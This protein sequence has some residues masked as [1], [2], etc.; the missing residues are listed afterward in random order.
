MSPGVVTEDLPA[1]LLITGRLIAV[2]PFE[3]REKRMSQAP[4]P[5]DTARGYMTPSVRQFSVFLPNMVGKL[6]ELLEIINSRPTLRICALSVADAA[7]YAVIRIIPSNSAEARLVLREH[8]LS[9]SEVDLLVVEVTP[10]H[11]LTQLCLYLLG[12]EL[13][14]RFAYPLFLG[15]GDSPTIAV[16]VDDH[17]LAGQILRHKNF[18]LLGEADLL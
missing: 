13:N 15:P 2:A 17:T 8:A 16:S 18:R 5:M 9:F 1:A 14:I 6:Y 12:A 10:D 7:D 11:S 3:S 4:T